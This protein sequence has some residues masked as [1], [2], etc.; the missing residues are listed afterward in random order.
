[1]LEYLDSYINEF[2]AFP[3]GG[4]DDCVDMTTQILL[5][6][7]GGMTWLDELVKQDVKDESANKFTE[8]VA[9]AVGWNTDEWG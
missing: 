5:K 9:A 7:G 2:K 8:T 6:L 3:F 4:N 1:M